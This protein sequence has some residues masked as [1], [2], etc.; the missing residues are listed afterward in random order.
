MGFNS[1]FKGLTAALHCVSF[2]TWRFRFFLFHLQMEESELDF[3]RLHF[4]V[5]CYHLQTG[6]DKANDTYRCVTLFHTRG[7]HEEQFTFYENNF[8]VRQQFYLRRNYFWF[9]LNLLSCDAVSLGKNLPTFRRI[10]LPRLLLKACQLPNHKQ[11]SYRRRRR[12]ILVLSRDVLQFRKNK[13]KMSRH[14]HRIVYCGGRG[15]LC[16]C[17]YFMF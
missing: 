17:M 9:G 11:G 4:A 3:W 10:M 12:W 2:T 15:R 8:I 5:I 1:G 7:Q 16:G 6:T 13:S 14:G